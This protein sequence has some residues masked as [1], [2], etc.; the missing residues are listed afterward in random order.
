MNAAGPLGD[1]PL[2][3]I[4]ISEQP[5]GAETLNALQAELVG[6][7]TNAVRR[8]VPG[9]THESLVARRHHVAVVAEAIR[10]A[11]AG[12]PDGRVE[13]RWAGPRR[14]AV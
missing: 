8:I 3:V 1:L 5:R 6:L 7:S 14:S 2:A 12:G 4:G 11:A 10:A 13:D 9:A